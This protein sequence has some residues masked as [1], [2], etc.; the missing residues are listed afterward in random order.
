MSCAGL[1]TSHANLPMLSRTHGQPATP[2]TL[3]KE[4]ANFVARLDAAMRGLAR[5]QVLGKMNGAVG[6]YNAHKIAY[7]DLDWPALSRRF[8]RS[9]GLVLQRL[10][11][12][13][14]TA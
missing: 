2:T 14:R 6:N 5:V 11:H 4:M 1:R 9:L 7:P 12:A 10:H 8:V 13:D 3:G